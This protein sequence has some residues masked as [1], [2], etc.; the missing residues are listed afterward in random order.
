MIQFLRSF[1]TFAI[2][3]MLVASGPAWAGDPPPKLAGAADAMS[4]AF[5]P[6]FDFDKDGC[7]PSVAIGR[8]GALNPGEDRNGTPQGRCRDESDLDNSNTYARTVCKLGGGS[9]GNRVYCGTV[10]SLYFQKDQVLPLSACDGCDAAGHRHDVENVVVWTISQNDNNW[11]IGNKVITDVAVSQHHGYQLLAGNNTAV[12]YM[13]STR[14]NVKIV[15]HKD[16]GSTHVLRFANSGDD[17][18]ENHKGV[19]WSPTLVQWEMMYGDGA[20]NNAALRALFNNDNWGA[21]FHFN[22]NRVCSTLSASKPASF[23]TIC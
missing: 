6:Y 20:I 21:A 15:Y 3:I 17:A 23:P 4:A 14:R 16:G 22:D 11:D 12:R 5:V 10:Y 2:G 1:M 8:N 19:W 9:W 18:I 7:Y 13:D